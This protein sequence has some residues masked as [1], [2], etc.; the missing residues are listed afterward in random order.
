MDISSVSLD[1]NNNNN[2]RVHAHIKNKRGIRHG[3][4]Q[5]SSHEK[6]PLQIK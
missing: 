3:E 6:I 1:D 2:N 4:T 5:S